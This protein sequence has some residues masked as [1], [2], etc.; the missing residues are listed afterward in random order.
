MP[1]V[2]AAPTPTP[3][4][5]EP[6]KIPPPV[7]AGSQGAAALAEGEPKSTPVAE[8][9]LE[10]ELD[11]KGNKQKL[12]FANRDQLKAVLQKA[13]YADQVIKDGVQAKKGAEALMA[14][15]KTKEGLLEVLRDPDI[16]MDVKQFAIDQVTEMMNDE[17]LTPEQRENRELKKFKEMTEK[18][19]ADTLKAEEDKKAQ[20]QMDKQRQEIST[21]I[22]DAMKKYP[23]IPQTQATMDACILNMR[24]AYKRFGKHL[25]PEQAMSVYSE[26]YWK[27]HQSVVDKM[28]PEQL[29]ARFGQKTLD[30]LQQIRLNELKAKTDPSKKVASGSDEIKKKKHLTEKDFDKHFMSTALAGL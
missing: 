4:K 29:V 13:L 14:K 12:K 17:K 18:E 30:K 1:D 7:A 11:V 22:I 9:P 3:V 2:T 5:S 19:K 8:D 15:L 27:A 28:T 20:E 6:T 16:N 25:T 23:D 21:Q 26:Q 10:F 24:A